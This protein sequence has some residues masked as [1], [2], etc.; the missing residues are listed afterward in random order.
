MPSLL[1]SIIWEGTQCKTSIYFPCAKTSDLVTLQRAEK[2]LAAFGVTFTIEHN[3][4]LGIHTWK[5]D[6][7][8]DGPISVEFGGRA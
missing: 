8:L 7:S 1:P 6:E 4:E 5:W 2:A 3:D